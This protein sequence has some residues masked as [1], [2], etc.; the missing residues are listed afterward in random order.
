LNSGSGAFNVGAGELTFNFGTG[1]APGD[2]A[3]TVKGTLN[4]ATA[5][6]LTINIDS[7]VPLIPENDHLVLVTATTLNTIANIDDLSYTLTH[8]GYMYDSSHLELNGNELWLVFGTGVAVIP[9]VPEVE[10]IKLRYYTPTLTT[11]MRLINRAQDMI[12]DIS[13]SIRGMQDMFN[14]QLPEASSAYNSNNT[15]YGRSSGDSTNSSGSSSSSSN[16]RIAVFGSSGLNGSTYT[17]NK[18]TTRTNVSLFGFHILGRNLASSIFI[19]HGMGSYKTPMADTD[20]AIDAQL[21]LIGGGLFISYVPSPFPLRSHLY[22]EA[23]A[24]GGQSTQSLSEDMLTILQ[25]YGTYDKSE[26]KSNYTGGHVGI[27]YVIRPLG[28]LFTIDL[29]AKALYL[30]QKSGQEVIPLIGGGGGTT[31]ATTTPTERINITGIESQRARI[32][33]KFS[34][35]FENARA[36]SYYFEVGEDYELSGKVKSNAKDLG[37]EFV[38]DMK[39][40]THYAKIGLGAQTTN[41]RADFNIDGSAGVRKSV[42]ATLN[43]GYMFGDNTTTTKRK[44]S[45]VKK[46]VS[47]TP[48]LTVADRKIPDIH[49]DFN[50]VEPKENDEQLDAVAAKVKEQLAEYEEGEEKLERGDRNNNKARQRRGKPVL[51][52][53]HGDEIGTREQNYKIGAGR[54]AAV[55]DVLV[56][57]GVSKSGIDTKSEGKDKPI[58]TNKTA[59]GRAL[60]RRATI[61]VKRPRRAWDKYD[62]VTEDKLGKETPSK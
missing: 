52:T 35:R 3:L 27:G 33:A 12:V 19:S 30:T 53:G 32:G 36:F 14:M 48:P 23:S 55:A 24:Q 11:N 22:L 28:T 50:S 54:A 38:N 5:S 60:N 20:K 39:G 42:G 47:P 45:Y 21:S 15:E 40:A 43:L 51:V 61:E 18:D 17:N 29:H 58:A 41:F 56:K 25:S 9:V 10:T 57:R 34:K 59:E 44:P 26:T 6:G 16:Y 7:S 1:T 49:F 8:T 37:Y 13:Y 31:A 46:T 4:M 62:E 2:T